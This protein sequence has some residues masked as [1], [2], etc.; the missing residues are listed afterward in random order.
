M[1]RAANVN[2]LIER[3]GAIT[4]NLVV[5]RMLQRANAIVAPT[6]H[7]F[8][9][10]IGPEFLTADEARNSLEL[11]M[12]EHTDNS[13]IVGSSSHSN[14]SRTITLVFGDK[15]ISNTFADKV[16]NIFPNWTYSRIT[17]HKDLYNEALKKIAVYSKGLAQRLD[18]AM[19]QPA[20]ERCGQWSKL[21]RV[22]SADLGNSWVHWLYLAA[23]AD[24][25]RILRNPVK[26]INGR[27]C[28]FEDPTKNNPN[29]LVCRPYDDKVTLEWTTE[30]LEELGI[31]FSW[32]YIPH[33]AET[34]APKLQRY[35]GAWTHVAYVYFN[36]AA[37]VQH[38]IA[39][40]LVLSPRLV[41]YTKPETYNS[42]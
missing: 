15:V 13:Y 12:D 9:V 37:Q 40:T 35:D 20:L 30:Y 26:R 25:S 18:D 3:T 41:P 22:E 34:C 11:M 23:D 39:R 24:C 31:P 4:N 38:A 19:F 6:H 17:E 32:M 28:V 8:T 42:S 7:A 14:D 27:N 16:H 29:M 36:T 21:V 33:S 2:T 5:Q 1:S 10:K